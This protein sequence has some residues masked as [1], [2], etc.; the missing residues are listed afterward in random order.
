MSAIDRPVLEFAGGIT[1]GMDV[2]DF[3]QLQRPFEGD[4]IGRAAAEIED[5][6]DL[7][8]AAGQRL[9]MWLEAQGRAQKARDFAERPGPIF[10]VVDRQEPARLA[11]ADGQRR[12]HREL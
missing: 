3:L 6:L 9:D 1:L 4:G 2:G 7:R 11:G 8:Q 10:H 12:Q 5:V